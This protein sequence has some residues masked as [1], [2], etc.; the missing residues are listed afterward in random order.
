MSRKSN[1]IKSHLINCLELL[2]I[3]LG[4]VALGSVA[5]GSISLGSIAF[6][7]DSPS[8]NAIAALEAKCVAAIQRAE[9]SVVSIARISKIEGAAGFQVPNLE[10]MR[11]SGRSEDLFPTDADF[12]PADYGAGVVIDPSGLIVTAY[13]VLGDAKASEYF[14]W[15]RHKPFKATV[16]AAD[17][18]FD[19][20]VLKV[21]AKDLQPLP[22]GDAKEVKKGEFVIA[23]GNPQA[24]ARDGNVSATWSMVANVKRRAPAVSERVNAGT[25]RETLH[26]YGTLIQIDTRLHLGYSGGALVNLDGEMIGLTTAYA[27]NA[28]E[29][30]SASFAIPVDEHFQQA[31]NQ[32]K[33]GKSPEFGFLGIGLEPVDARTRRQG[34][35]GVVVESVMTGTPAARAE[36]QPGD[37]IT[38][39][40]DVQLFDDDDLIRE[41][42]GLPTGQTVKLAVLRTGASPSKVEVLE[43]LAV[44]SKRPATTLR[45]TIATV[46]A[47]SW[48]GMQV[49]DAT[50]APRE[51]LL[52]VQLPISGGLYV[53]EVAH[54]S[55]S[56][57]AGLRPGVFVTAIAGQPVTTAREFFAA[58]AEQTGDVPLQLLTATGATTVQT[59]SP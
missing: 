34:R 4:S 2:L 44:L 56:W 39:C 50:A 52:T 53:T 40:N 21:D 25:G 46:P 31:L 26:H 27:G 38:H 30:Q 18:W 59:V 42:S 3:A 6:G 12:V 29:A 45:P 1:L 36:L 33:A 24:I 48:R 10:R 51:A 23:L 8:A 47:P 13:H 16:V 5:L 54:D 49:D 28:A 9:K 55:A 43:K 17:G 32:L 41:V 22:L 7:Q 57:K 11:I 35:H 14:V 19:L 58:I 37:V 20:A 15:S